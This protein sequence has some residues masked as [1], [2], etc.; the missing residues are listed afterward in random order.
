MPSQPAPSQPAPSSERMETA[1]GFIIA[2]SPRAARRQLHVSLGLM[3]VI[4]AGVAAMIAINGPP[5]R[6]AS[7]H[8]A[9]ETS[10]TRLVVQ[11]TF[12]RPATAAREDVARQ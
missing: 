9:Q 5:N 12:V 4:A 3:G 10:A 2:V 8:L 7:N 6:A 1:D 11:P